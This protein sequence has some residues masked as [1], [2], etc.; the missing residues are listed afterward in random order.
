MQVGFGW[1]TPEEKLGT[2]T[3]RCVISNHI[4]VDDSP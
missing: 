4:S 1:Q 2:N 3:H